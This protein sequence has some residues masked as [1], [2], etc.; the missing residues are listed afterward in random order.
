MGD[1]AHH[2]GQNFHSMKRRIWFLVNGGPFG[3]AETQLVRLAGW[4]SDSGHEVKVLTLLSSPEIQAELSRRGV[5]VQTARM[6]IPRGATAIAS[7]AGMLR[8]DRPDALLCF[9]YQSTVAGRLAGRLAH[10]PLIVSSMRNVYIGPRRRSVIL[11][12]TRRLSSVTVVNSRQ[13]GKTLL[14]RGVLTEKLEVIPN[15]VERGKFIRSSAVT[16]TARKELGLEQHAFVWLAAGR[17]NPQKDFRSLIAAFSKFQTSFPESVLLIAGQGPERASLE[18]EATRRSVAGQIQFLG[19]RDDM[20]RLLAAADALV[21][22]SA[23]EGVPNVILEALRASLP[24]VATKVGGVTEIIPPGLTPYLV[25]PGDPDSLA[26]AMIRLAALDGPD[27]LELGDEGRRFVEDQFDIEEIGKK[28]LALI[29][30]HF[31]AFEAG[32]GK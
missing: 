31:R 1:L 3:G 27:R 25:P 22:S 23:W 32:A 17:L 29:E 11:R 10:V 15:A 14:D 18:A 20:P 7:L 2:P 9:L 26:Q 8:R 13:V 5:Q 19:Y 30:S 4:L 16:Q 28:W 21:L 24:V 12:M 6:S